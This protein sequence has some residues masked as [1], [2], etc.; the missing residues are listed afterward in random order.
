[1]RVLH[2][3]ESL[4][5]GG[6]EKIVVS[7]ANGMVGSHEVSICCVKRIGALGAELDERVQVL[8]LNKGEGNDYLLPVRLAWLLR[9]YRIDVVHTHSW[10]VFLEAGLAG[11]LAR[12]PVVVHT[13]HGPYMEYSDSVSSRLKIGVRHALEWLVA[14]QFYRIVTVSD[15]IRGYIERTVHIAAER[16]LTLHN[17]IPVVSRPPERPERET[18]TFVSVG[19]LAAVKNHQLML[20]AFHAVSMRHTNVRLVIVGDGPERS[21]IESEIKQKQMEDKVAVLGFRRDVDMVLAEAD[22]FVSTSRYE[23]IS[24]ALLEAMRCGLPAVCTSVG[25]MP[26]TVVDGKTGFLVAPDE[27][28]S[29]AEAM[30]ALASSRTLRERMGTEGYE[31]FVRDFSLNAMLSRYE[32]LYRQGIG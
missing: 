14:R 8:C 21:A 25:G 18:V 19:R 9:Q 32:Q 1:V 20:R 30:S 5:F 2:I 31:F 27:W 17:G 23:G 13:V 11:L 29:L 6:A 28:E 26:E 16:L 22:V 12:T 24:I 7:L 3:I 4:E 15:D 10:A